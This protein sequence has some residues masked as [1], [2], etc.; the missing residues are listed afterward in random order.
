MYKHLNAMAKK[1]LLEELKKNFSKKF[2]SK[3]LYKRCELELDILYERELLFIIEY[4]YK[5]KIENNNVKYSFGGTINNLLLLYVLG[6]NFVNPLEYNLV[7][8]LFNDSTIKVAVTN[9]PSICFIDYL[10]SQSDKFKLIHGFYVKIEIKSINDLLDNNYLLIPSDYLDSNMLLRFNDMAI[11]ETVNDYQTYLKKYLAIKIDEKYYIDDDKV[12][13]DNVF[14]ND[15][16]RKIARILKPKKIDD[17][18]KIKS[19]AHGTNVWNDNQDKL[20]KD[21]KLDI[22]NLIATRDDILQYLLD[23][24]IEKTLALEIT[25]FIRKGKALKSPDK[26]NEYV[27]VMRE[28]GCEDMYIEIFSKILFISCRGQAVSECL[29][30]LDEDNYIKN[31]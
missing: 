29:F 19:L 27:K 6:I 28:N 10:N 4:L 22:N 11:L 9:E 1:Y 21:K 14:T 20:V 23:H 16:E 13:F 24:K 7:S 2:N 18:I 12:S 3:D 31:N 15:F 17:Y 26:W 5:Y 8:E 25:N 30:A